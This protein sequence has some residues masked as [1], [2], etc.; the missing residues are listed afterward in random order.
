MKNYMQL[1]LV[2]AMS[3]IALTGCA[4]DDIELQVSSEGETNPYA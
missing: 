4:N 1:T 2:A 3:I